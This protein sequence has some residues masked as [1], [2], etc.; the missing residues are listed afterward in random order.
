LNVTVLEP[1][2]APKFTP[3]MITEVVTGP[4]EGSRLVMPG[5][6]PTVKLTP[7]LATPPTV[8]TTF[9]LVAPL[10]TGTTMLVAP[11]VVGV[12]IVPLKVTVLVPFVDP[13]FVPMIV[14]DVLTD[15]ETGLKPV[16]PGPELGLKI[17]QLLD[18]P[19]TVT[20]THPRVAPEGTVTAIVV[21]FQL[22]TPAG[23]PLKVTVLEPCVDP[24]LDPVIV[25]DVL[26]GPE[27]GL[28]LTMSGAKPGVKITQLLDTPPTIT[29]TH[30]AIP[31]IPVGT[32]TTMVVG[33]QLVGVPATPLNVTV[34]VP[35]V[36]PKLVPVIVTDVP[37]GPEPGE[38][39]VIIGAAVEVT[40]KSRPLL[41]IPPTV[42]ST[43][44][45]V[46]PVGT[47]TTM[48]VSPQLVAVAIVPL[49][50]M[51]LVPCAAPKIVPVIVTDVPTGPEFGER[52]AMRG[53]TTF[54]LYNS[55]L[56]SAPLLLFP[57]ATRTC[58]LFS[59]VAVAELRAVFRLAV[60]VNVPLAGL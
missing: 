28:T 14:T 12:A 43:L 25:T 36:D 42:T 18:S 52:L 33:L 58:P 9:P 16:I 11:Q 23:V 55:A 22:V 57:P 45:V 49:K 17:A 20:T 46:A 56:E 26:A 2:D 30:P 8:T 19:P 35:C 27:V 44:P 48:L 5:P 51:V 31:P 54:N 10:G 13:K 59:S 4:A 50:V 41:A 6:E 7:L 21:V 53:S 15:P 39:P 24:K 29:T 37:I 34:L 32:G 1:C 47:G 38:T 60:V 40:M 3:L